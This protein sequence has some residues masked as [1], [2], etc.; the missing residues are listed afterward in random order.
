M[1][2]SLRL[3]QIIQVRQEVALL[4]HGHHISRSYRGIELRE[5]AYSRLPVLL[6]Q[7]GSIF[8]KLSELS[9]W[10]LFWRRVT[11]HYLLGSQPMARIHGRRCNA[12]P[13]HE[14]C[15]HSHAGAANMLF[16]CVLAGWFSFVVGGPDAW[17]ELG[18]LRHT[19]GLDVQLAKKH[20]STAPQA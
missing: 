16:R 6:I 19:C 14:Q 5:R 9:V 1:L 10:D 4:S 8:C 15:I 13:L 12:T 2:L 17:L 3:H 11:P 20:P 18:G 7:P